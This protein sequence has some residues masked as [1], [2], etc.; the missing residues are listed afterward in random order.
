MAVRCEGDCRVMEQLGEKQDLESELSRRGY[1]HDAF[2]LHV[3]RANALDHG[4]NPTA[5]YAV[6]VTSTATKRSNVYWGGPGKHWLS[7]FVDDVAIGFYGPPE[8]N[9]TNGHPARA[10]A[11]PRLVAVGAKRA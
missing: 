7:E 4:K 11:R 2:L 3:R 9:R 5:N 6:C 8:M 10:V 1:S